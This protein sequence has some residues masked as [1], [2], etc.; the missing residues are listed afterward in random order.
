LLLVK[1]SK[2]AKTIQA[3]GAAELLSSADLF[4][5]FSR[6]EVEYLASRSEFLDLADGQ[7]VFSAGEASSCLFLVA[8]GA[9]VILSPENGTV[10]AEFVAGDSFGELEF[11]TGAAHNAGARAGGP[12]R[13]LVFPSRGQDLGRALS[14]RPEVAARVYRSF[15]LVVAGRTRKANALVKE[16]SPL[17]RELK[18]QVYGDK[19]TG[20]LNKAWLEE[21]LPGLLTGALALLMLKPD[22]FKDIN[23][24]FGHEVGDAVLVLMAGEFGHALDGVAPAV[25]Y[26]GNELCA[27]FAG[28][29][30]EEALEAAGALKARLE[31]LDL[32]ALTKEP[33][34][35]LS[36]SMGLALF[37]AHGST[38]EDLIRICAA[39]PLAGRARGG[40]LI[41]FPEDAP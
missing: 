6:S 26:L 10:M 30:R 17:V 36:I 28:L 3:P 23:D 5:S 29:G 12:T 40:S 32:S 33:G 24:R 21:G 14:E 16:N 11:L 31:A 38:A 37:P 41:L 18:R 25:R 4:S 39:L 8:E 34:L 27:V 35:R 22:N 2:K 1:A 19:L 13:L 9:V 7:A 15:L 20:L